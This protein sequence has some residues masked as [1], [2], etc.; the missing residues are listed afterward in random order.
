MS[1][2]VKLDHTGKIC[3]I[4]HRETSASELRA[5]GKISTSNTDKSNAGNYNDDARKGGGSGGGGSG[6][7]GS[8]DSGCKDPNGEVVLSLPMAVD[9]DEVL[10]PQI[11]QEFFISKIPN[12]WDKRVRLCGPYFVACCL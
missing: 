2:V 1:D 9:H 10:S 4:L 8:G 7:S 6:D 11:M 3:D 5:E 12:Q